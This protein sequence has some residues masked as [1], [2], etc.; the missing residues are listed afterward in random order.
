MMFCDPKLRD[1]EETRNQLLLNSWFG[2]TAPKPSAR[3][4]TLPCS[5]TEPIEG[6]ERASVPLAPFWAALMRA[7]YSRL[8]SLGRKLTTAVTMLSLKMAES[9]SPNSSKARANCVLFEPETMTLPGA[10]LMAALLL[11]PAPGVFQNE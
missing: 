5:S 7:T 2:P 9:V 1:R 6:T 4:C 11:T 8:G 10:L 3:K